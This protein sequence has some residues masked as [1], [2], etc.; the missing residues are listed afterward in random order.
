MVNIVTTTCTGCASA[1]AKSR[2]TSQVSKESA[3]GA[4][5]PP[6]R[7]RRGCGWIRQSKRLRPTPTASRSGSTRSSADGVTQARRGCAV[8]SAAG[9]VRPRPEHG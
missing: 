7:G 8:G 4:S 1:S 5:C 3:G 9:G 2:W 6:A